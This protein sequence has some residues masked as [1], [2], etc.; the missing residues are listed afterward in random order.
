MTE[1]IR[2]LAMI[3]VLVLLSSVCG[4]TEESLA[5][6]EPCQPGWATGIYS[7][8]TFDG[9][10]FYGIEIFVLWSEGSDYVV[11]QSAEG[12]LG[13]PLI[14]K[15]TRT[16]D[17]RISFV[18]PESSPSFHAGAEFEG[19]ISQC[20][21]RGSFDGGPGSPRGENEFTLRRGSYWHP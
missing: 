12:G 9:E 11:F 2:N 7:S 17:G 6:T 21:I 3:G 18:L 13:P 20:E 19:S 5:Q 14:A 4:L 1:S 15:A 16:T 10:H 8:L